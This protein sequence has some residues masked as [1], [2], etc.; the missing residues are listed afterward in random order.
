MVKIDRQLHTWNREGTLPNHLWFACLYLIL[1]CVIAAL[2]LS[3]AASFL[4]DLVG[5]SAAWLILLVIG[6]LFA[7]SINQ[8]IIPSLNLLD[9]RLEWMTFTL[10]SLW[11]GLIAWVMLTGLKANAMI[12]FVGQ[13]LQPGYLSS[14]VL[15]IV[16]SLACGVVGWRFVGRFRY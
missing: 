8:V 12:W 6:S 2:V 14:I 9:K 11:I 3:I 15:L 10:L 5:I 4:F 1:V 16:A 7:N 13:Y